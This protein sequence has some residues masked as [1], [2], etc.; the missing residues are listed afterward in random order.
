M[1][2]KTCNV[3]RAKTVL[4]QNTKIL[5][6]IFGVI[7]CSNYFPPRELLNEFLMGGI[8]SCDQDGRMPPWQPFA[9]LPEEYVAIEA[10]WSELNPGTCTD[11]L[12][13]ANWSEWAVAVLESMDP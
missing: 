8:D 2:S 12:A 4:L 9:L 13:A 7:A 1:G 11:R 3:E 6:G 10:W 5:Y